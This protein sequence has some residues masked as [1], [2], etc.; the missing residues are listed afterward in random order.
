MIYW[1]TGLPSA[2]KTTVAKATQEYLWN[3]YGEKAVIIDADDVR[4]TVNAGLGFSDEDR[5]RNVCNLAHMAK[6]VHDGGGTAIVACIAP[7]L[8]MRQEAILIMKDP[9]RWVYLS[10]GEEVRVERDSRGLYARY[11]AGEITGLTG[12]DAPY[13]EPE[14]MMMINTECTT[15]VDAAIAI[16]WKRDMKRAVYIGR[17]C[18]FHNGHKAIIDK[19]LE[20]GANPLVLVR[21]TDETFSVGERIEMI[22]AVYAGNPRVQV[23]AFEDVESVCIGRKVGYDVIRYDMPEDV[24]GISGTVVRALIEQGNEEWRQFVPKEVVGVIE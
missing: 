6:A 8:E 12:M 24:E 13:D 14:L 17:W 20:D 15:P 2:G 10:C 21:K 1:L 11:K 22:R 7:L 18:P 5:M 9:V 19:G 4:Q 23:E 16:A 3:R